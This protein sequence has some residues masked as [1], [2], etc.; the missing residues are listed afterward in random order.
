MKKI[1]SF[2]RWWFTGL[3]TTSRTVT[4]EN[5]SRNV[6]KGAIFRN[7]AVCFCLSYAF[8]AIFISAESIVFI[9]ILGS[10][11]GL[12]AG[13]NLSASLGLF[14]SKSIRGE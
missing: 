13:S 11:L 7:Y 8:I 10:V 9:I 14:F 4:G 5:H 2:L 3:N 6:R 12:M 1:S